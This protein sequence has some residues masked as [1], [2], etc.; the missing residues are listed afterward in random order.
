MKVLV[1]GFSSPKHCEI[2]LGLTERSFDVIY[3]VAKKRVKKFID[4]HDNIFK[5]T[6]F[7]DYTD[8]L[9]AIPPEGLDVSDF[10]PVGTDIIEAL[11]KHEPQ[12]L[13]LMTRIDFGDIPFLEKHHR[14]Y[15]YV[16]YWYGVLSKMKPDVVVF[17]DIPHIVF[18]TVLYHVAKFLG[19]KTVIKR[20]LTSMRDYVAFFG[21]MYDYK[22]VREEYAR[23]KETVSSV[24]Q[25]ETG[26][27]E[28][29]DGLS[30][31]SKKNLPKF[32]KAYFGESGKEK[33]VEVI[34]AF[35]RIIHNIKKF[36]FTKTAIE[37]IKLLFKRRQMCSI[38]KRSELGIVT[39]W[40][41]IRYKKMR[42]QFKEEYVSLQN[43]E[44]DFSI[45]YVYFPLHAQPEATTNP[46]GG[47]YTD[48]ILATDLLAKAL[49]EGWK[50][51]IKEHKDQW[52]LPRVH[53]GRYPGYYK[54]MSRHK[55]VELVSAEISGFDMINNA[56]AVAT[57]AGSTAIE[58][59][60]RG[61]NAFIFGYPMYVECDGMFHI[62]TFD[63]CKAAVQKVQ[64]GYVPTSLNVLRFFQA[65]KNCSVGAYIHRRHGIGSKYSREESIKNMME[66]L[67]TA[68][69]K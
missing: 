47:I 57:I 34:P 60:A 1:S 9:A 18:D 19:I 65:L 56:K 13:S 69:M 20:S 48:Q 68:C 30:K 3:W 22:E 54:T 41:N 17:H 16:S 6:L 64:E 15:Q 28:L 2:I 52:V 40:H 33:E 51:Y 8:A 38:T 39:R 49:P 4:E 25:I 37:Y 31:M 53:T 62:T 23:L 67:Y 7:H 45:P 14:Y 44:P 35:S 55:N 26:V 50:L 29:Y 42:K 58:A 36:R 12:V 21:D 5:K 11:V 24:D 59:V 27:Q 63:S 43:E 10:D 46:M 66:G 32:Y 61:K